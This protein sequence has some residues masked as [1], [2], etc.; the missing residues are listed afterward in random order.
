MPQIRQIGTVMVAADLLLASPANSRSGTDS[1]ELPARL[2][3][4]PHGPPLAVEV[5]APDALWQPSTSLAG[6]KVEG[7]SATL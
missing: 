5:K 4:T 7:L 6:L 2:R 3:L 1:V